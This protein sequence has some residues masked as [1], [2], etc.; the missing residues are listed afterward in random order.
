[1]EIPPVSKVTPLPTKAKGE[2]S[3]DF[4]PRFFGL[5]FHCITTNFELRMLP[6]PTPSKAP[7]P[8]RRIWVSP[9]ISTLTPSFSSVLA[10]FARVSGYNT[11]GGSE[12]RSRVKKIPS[13]TLSNVLNIDLAFKKAPQWKAIDLRLDFSDSFCFVLYLSKR[14]ERNRVPNAICAATCAVFNFDPDTGSTAIATTP[15][16]AR[17]VSE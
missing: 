9:S 7:I 11:L 6:C 14:Y 2:L 4:C 16:T 3:F 12:T 13:A 5:P 8:R 17:Y 15:L 1:M 10:C